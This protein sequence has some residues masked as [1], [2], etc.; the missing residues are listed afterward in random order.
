MTNRVNLQELARAVA[1]RPELGPS[2]QRI[3]VETIRLL[4]G[5]EPVSPAEVAEAAGVATQ[6]ARESLGSW[7]LTSWDDEDRLVGFCGLSID[8]L[9]P[10][11]RLEVNG[12]T[13][14]GWCAWDTLFITQILRTTTRVESSDPLTGEAVRLIVTPEGVE[15]VRPYGA[16]VSFLLTEACFGPDPVQRFCHFVHFFASAESGRRWVADHPGTFLLSVDEAFELGRLA[17]RLR[18]PRA[19]GGG[20][21]VEDGARPVRRSGTSEPPAPAGRSAAPGPPP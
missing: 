18:I 1:A 14:Y 6:Q 20:E 19:L 3:L 2:D 9:E 10:T 21:V 7:P 13:V 8:R 15:E 16:V 12:R 5:G 11:H 17:N 4:A